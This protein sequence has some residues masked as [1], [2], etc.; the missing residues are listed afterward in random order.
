MQTQDQQRNCVPTHAKGNHAK[1]ITKEEQQLLFDEYN[2]CQLYAERKNWILNCMLQTPIKRKRTNELISRRKNT[3][4]YTVVVKGV[5]KKVC[6]QFMMKTLDVSQ[7]T[8]RHTINNSIDTYKA[9]PDMRGKILPKNK[10]P[11]EQVEDVKRFI[12]I[13]P[14]VPSHYCKKKIKKLYLPTDIGNIIIN[15]E[16]LYIHYCKN[17]NKV[18]VKKRS[19]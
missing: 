12:E 11:L 18:P 15:L 3:V 17:N 1:M 9:K 4:E 8:L 10:T 14:V 19:V 7:M 2:K 16:S 6:Q 5:K 13:I